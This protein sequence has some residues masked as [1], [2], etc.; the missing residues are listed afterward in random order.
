MMISNRKKNL[1]P[2]GFIQNYFSAWRVTFQ[3]KLNC[4]IYICTLL[5]PSS[6]MFKKLYFCLQNADSHDEKNGAI[7]FKETPRITSLVGLPAVTTLYY[8]CYYHY[9]LEE[10]KLASPTAIRKAYRVSD[11]RIHVYLVSEHSLLKH[12]IS[13]SIRTY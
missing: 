1:W 9:E 5:T 11:N 2:P 12:F 6:T 13:T 10:S 4:T 8:C 7:K 3:W